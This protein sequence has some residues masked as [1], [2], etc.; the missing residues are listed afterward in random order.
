[1]RRA[2]PHLTWRLDGDE[3]PD[4]KRAGG[5]VIVDGAKGD[6]AHYRITVQKSK[7]TELSLESDR[8]GCYE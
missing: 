2:Y 4:A 5:D 3:I 8:S 7:V 1:V 6:G